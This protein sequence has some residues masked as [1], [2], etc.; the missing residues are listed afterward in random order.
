VIDSRSAGDIGDLMLVC[1]FVITRLV[2]ETRT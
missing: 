1:F 2:N